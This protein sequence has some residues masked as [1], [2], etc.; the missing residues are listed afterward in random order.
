[1]AEPAEKSDD[2]TD[3]TDS[4][5]AKHHDDVA[6]FRP[7]G[8]AQTFA[9]ADEYRDGVDVQA[10]ISRV[11]W[12]FDELVRNVRADDDLDPAQQ[13]AKIRALTDELP[14]QLDRAAVKSYPFRWTK[15]FTYEP[16]PADSD[17]RGV[18]L[19]ASDFA[20]VGDFEDPTT[21]A[22]TTIGSRSGEYSTARIEQSI[23]RLQAGEKLHSDR[24]V[25]IARLTAAAEA[26][27]GSA[28][29]LLARMGA[30][31]QES[32]RFSMFKDAAG[33]LRWLTVHTNVFTDRE[34]ERFPEA[35]HR[36]FVE[37]VDED[38]KERGPE[39]RLW[40]MPGTGLGRADVVAFDQ[41]FVL[42]SGKFYEG[43]EAE[44]ER[45]AEAAKSQ[46]LACSHGYLYDAAQRKDGVYGRYRTFEVSVLPANKAANELTGFVAGRKVP[47]MDA[48][49]RAFLA[50]VLGGDDQIDKL[51]TGLA[52]MRAEAEEKGI[53]AV[54]YKAMEE[55]LIAGLS[56]TKADDDAGDETGEKAKSG[57][58]DHAGGSKEL[59]PLVE[60]VTELSEFV[61]SLGEKVIA[62][63]AQIAELAK[64]D[65]EKIAATLTARPPGGGFV[66]SESKD[67]V[68]DNAASQAAKEEG[69]SR[70]GVPASLAGYFGEGGE[71]MGLNKRIGLTEAPPASP[72]LQK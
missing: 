22:L 56:G 61:K 66:A 62:Q 31:S 8:G 52:E 43:R 45:L 29:D 13:M 42:A 18:M 21:W 69:A 55:R 59:A 67:T 34:G 17:Q 58:H 2:T 10:E 47:T 65:D 33:D 7:L 71:L 38:V 1:V 14:A 5:G 9:E 20:D 27:G 41:G 26:A 28:V 48:E 35:S 46:D 25:V 23:Q 60:A 40:H 51:E 16:V 44:A 50:G 68:V 11:M 54:D 19:K 39:L 70:P 6:E 37:W 36:E 15:D 3:G 72:G 24:D 53:S 63:D 32:G 49:K 12:D 30:P 64:S 57:E 4:Q